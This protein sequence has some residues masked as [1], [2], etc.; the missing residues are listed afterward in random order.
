MSEFVLELDGAAYRASLL[1]A[2][3]EFVATSPP[4]RT[5]LVVKVPTADGDREVRFAGLIRKPELADLE[6]IAAD[7][8]TVRLGSGGAD[9]T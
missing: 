2:L 9:P 3:R 8:E 6:A 5:Q 7:H 1:P 4:G